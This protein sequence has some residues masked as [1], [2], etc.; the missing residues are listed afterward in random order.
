MKAPTHQAP[1]SDSA[2]KE[3]AVEGVRQRL[4]NR[5]VMRQIR[6]WVER[7]AH[8]QRVE[9]LAWRLALILVVI[10]VIGAILYGLHHANYF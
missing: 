10:S 2:D 3:Q 6:S 7:D 4:T 8:E 5:L 1:Q 9:Q